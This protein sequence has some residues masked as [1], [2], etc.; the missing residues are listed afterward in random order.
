MADWT[1]RAWN[2]EIAGGQFFGGGL[3]SGRAWPLMQ[4]DLVPPVIASVLPTSGTNILAAQSL[5]F[6]VTDNNAFRRIVVRIKRTGSSTWE[7]VHDGDTFSPGWTLNSTRSSI[8]GGYHYAIR[9]DGNWSV[10][11]TPRLTVYAIDIGGN[12]AP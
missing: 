5:S 12:E 3:W 7:F 2:K 4:G 6:D 10:G 8:L 11:A 9:P 1:G